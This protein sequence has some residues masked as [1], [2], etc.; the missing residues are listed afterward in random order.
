MNCLVYIIHVPVGIVFHGL[1]E[2]FHIPLYLNTS[3]AY[4]GIGDGNLIVSAPAAVVVIVVAQFAHLKL[5]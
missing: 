1:M 3:D 2:I 4:M 5:L